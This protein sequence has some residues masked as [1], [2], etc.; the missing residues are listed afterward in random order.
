MQAV[1]SPA[2]TSRLFVVAGYAAIVSGVLALPMIAALVAMFVGFALGP[3]AR[4]AALRFGTI[5]DLLI[6]VVYA[7]LLPVIPAMHVVVR[8]TGSVRSLL[9]ATVG[10][11]GIVITIV[12]TWLLIIGAM[13]FEQQVGPVSVSLLAAGAWILGTSYLARNVGFLPHGLRNG[14]LGALYLGIPVWGIDL[15]RRL[16]GG[17]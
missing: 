3:D 6:I 5:N 9:L 15:G 10:T 2:E 17:R 13:P 7:L 16:L 8:E 1:G 4:Q 12:L 14:V 11:A